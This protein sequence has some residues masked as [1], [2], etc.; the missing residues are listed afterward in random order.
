MSRQGAEGVLLV[1]QT[2]TPGQRLLESR[3][4]EREGGSCWTHFV[5]LLKFLGKSNTNSH[6]TVSPMCVDT[7][8]DE[9]FGSKRPVS[10]VFS[11]MFDPNDDAHRKKLLTAATM[12]SQRPHREQMHGFLENVENVLSLVP[13]HLYNRHQD[14]RSI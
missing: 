3:N 7:I 13:C 2:G 4:A 12:A 11:A 5:D 9:K 1:F 8:E 10:R 14:D 6:K